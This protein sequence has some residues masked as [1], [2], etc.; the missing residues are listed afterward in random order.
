MAIENVSRLLRRSDEVLHLRGTD[1]V[2]QRV[3]RRH[4]ADEDQHDQAHAF[5]PVVGAV[6][7]AD[8]GAGKHHQRANGKRRR[9]IVFGAS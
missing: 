2:V 7:E 1:G 9:L 8:A 6:E 3:S 4:R 5:L